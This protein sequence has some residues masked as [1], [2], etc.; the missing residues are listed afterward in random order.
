MPELSL[1]GFLPQDPDGEQRLLAVLE[2]I[3]P[4]AIAV[5]ENASVLTLDAP[6]AVLAVI[7]ERLDDPRQLEFWRK[8]L[9]PEHVHYPA[10]AS[11]A[12]GARHDRPVY[13]LGDDT[14]P[15]SADEAQALVQLDAETLRGMAAFDWQHMYAQDYARARRDLEAQGCIEFLVPL[16]QQALFRERERALA[17]QVEQLLV[18]LETQ[19][20][21]LVCGIPHL[22]YSDTQLT[23]Y[24]QLGPGAVRRFV[25]DGHGEVRDVAI[26]TRPDGRG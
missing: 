25:T 6:K 23:L 9:A 5:E 17:K 20:L 4:A 11:A 3:Q 14:D 19:R 13:F 24:R 15:D 18:R 26:A 7:S 22:Y 2:T 21:A 1:I 16:A 10:F 12:Y 8:R